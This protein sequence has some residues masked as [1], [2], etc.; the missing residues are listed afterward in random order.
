MA[1]SEDTA[2]ARDVRGAS[3]RRGLGFVAIS[4]VA[5]VGVLGAATFG[6][7]AVS[8]GTRGEPAELQAPPVDP[9]DRELEIDLARRM[10]DV[11]RSRP[12]AV[13]SVLERRPA[14]TEAPPPIPRPHREH[15]HARRARRTR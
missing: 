4:T 3:P 5:L 11:E 12:G 14:S 8:L 1:D 7:R 9:M 10:R 6:P 2:R 13:D 15:P